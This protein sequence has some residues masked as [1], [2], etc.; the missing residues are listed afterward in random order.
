LLGE[1]DGIFVGLSVMLLKVT[2]GSSVGFVLG[3]DD[4][5]LEGSAVG[6]FVGEDVGAKEGSA[7]GFFVGEEDGA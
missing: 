7:V 2:V 6:F 5:A 3:E 1:E 4:G